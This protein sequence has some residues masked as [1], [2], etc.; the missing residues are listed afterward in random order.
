MRRRRGFTLVEAMISIVIVGGLLVVALR[1][2]GASRY[3]RYKMGQRQRG[4]M[5][6]R[7]MMSEILNQ[8]YAEP[9]D[10]P[11]FGYEMNEGRISRSIYDDVDDYNAWRAS[12]P[13]NKDGTAI[14]AMSGWTRTVVVRYVREDDYT[15]QSGT[16]EGAKRIEVEVSHNGLPVAT[17]WAV[18]TNNDQLVED[19]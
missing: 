13:Q 3:G 4:L 1:T 10:I 5:L 17:L 2:A 7:E 8:S 11:R 6:A 14:S 12:P 19:E 9:V 15:C 16:D 18:R